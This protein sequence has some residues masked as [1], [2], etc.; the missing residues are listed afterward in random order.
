VSSGSTTANATRVCRFGMVNVYLVREE[1]GLTLIDAGITGSTRAIL[2]AAGEIGLPIVRIILTHS[3]GDHIGSLDALHAELPDAEVLISTREVRLLRKDRTVD[4]GEPQGKPRGMFPGAKTTP[5]RTFEPG[6]TIGSLEVLASPGHTPGHVALLDHRD[7][8][9]FCGDAFSTLGGV[10]TTARVNP[11]FPLPGLATWDKPTAL[12][13]A[14]SLRTR[15]V[16][17]LAPGHGPIVEEPLAAMDAA[18]AKA[19]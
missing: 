14:R 1:D 2:A 3:H 16:K 8:T 10:A 7:R 11:L 15:E 4:Q 5:D 19:A 18:I 12:E 9:L 6:D 13:S 17:A